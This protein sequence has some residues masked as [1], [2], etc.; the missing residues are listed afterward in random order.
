MRTYTQASAPDSLSRQEFMGPWTCEMLHITLRRLTL[1]PPGWTWIL[2]SS[3]S[4]WRAPEQQQ[5]SSV[6]HFSKRFPQKLLCSYFISLPPVSGH[7]ALIVWA[8]L[9]RHGCNSAAWST[10]VRERFSFI[11]GIELRIPTEKS[12]LAFDRRFILIQCWRIMAVV[13]MGQ[14]PKWLSFGCTAFVSFTQ[15]YCKEICVDYFSF[16][17]FAPFKLF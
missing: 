4:Q 16:F 9:Y 10:G 12:H 13:K 3:K 17:P 6:L 1:S 5:G 7:D 2:F 11:C 14:G 15:T 8:A